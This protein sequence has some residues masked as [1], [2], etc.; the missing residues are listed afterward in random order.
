M[1]ILRRVHIRATMLALHKQHK[2]I[3]YYVTQTTRGNYR[4]TEIAPIASERLVAMPHH[5]RCEVDIVD[6]FMTSMYLRG[7]E[8][9]DAR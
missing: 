3:A 6:S 7:K 2:R 1:N 9:Q 8:W 4:L 5:V